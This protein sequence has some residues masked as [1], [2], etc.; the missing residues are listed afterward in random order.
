MFK[1]ETAMKLNCEAAESALVW[2]G[3]QN[4]GKWIDH[5]RFVS[6]A[7]KN[8][9][10]KCADLSADRAYCFGLLHDIGR[11]AGVTSERHLID[12]YRFCMERGWG[13]AAHSTFLTK[14]IGSWSISSKM[15]FMTTMTGS[16]N[17]AMHWR[18]RPDSA[19]LKKD[20]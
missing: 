2:A 8:I 3:K 17:Y 12:G 14:T 19:F 6:L 18:S 16:C 9:A 7:C 1:E 15:L 11:Y 13:K 5:S 10:A 20:L 4:P